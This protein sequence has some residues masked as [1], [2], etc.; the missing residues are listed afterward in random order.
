MLPETSLAGLHRMNR[1]LRSS[2]V[3]S[4][5]LEVVIIVS[6]VGR[7]A[8]VTFASIGA[9]ALAWLTGVLGLI[10]YS[11]HKSALRG[12][13]TVSGRQAIMDA[14][15][16][17]RPGGIH[18]AAYDPA[19]AHGFAYDSVPAPGYAGV[20]AGEAAA[21]AAV[22]GGVAL[23]GLGELG[24]AEVAAELAHEE[25]RSAAARSSCASGVCGSV[26]PVGH[27]DTG[28]GSAGSGD[29]SSS[30]SGDWGSAGWGGGDFGGGS[31]GWGGDSGGSSGG[32]S[33]GSS[34]GGSSC[35]GGGGCGG[36][37]GGG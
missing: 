12:L 28:S 1:G 37:C 26:L 2:V 14:R 16:R 33:G 9:V 11:R 29:W 17:R 27:G 36:G 7:L 23:Y 15:A 35:G 31:T 30:G 22:A 18:G 13:L 20:P 4:W 10:A 5:I 6:L 32:D 24:D 34:G 19:L 3:L 25:A 21:Y 8:P